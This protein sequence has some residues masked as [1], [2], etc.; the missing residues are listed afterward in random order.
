MTVN[1]R[2]RMLVPTSLFAMALSLAAGTLA[3]SQS[4]DVELPAGKGRDLVIKACSGC[5]GLKTAVEDRR[6]RTSWQDVV[7]EMKG[8]DAPV[9]DEEADALVDYLWQYFGRVNVNVA[10]EQ[11]IQAVAGLSASEAAAIVAYRTRHGDFHAL[12]ELKK[13]PRLDF[14]RI[15]A[16]RDRI[17]FTGR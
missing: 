6:T 2:R 10:S 17:A 4:N 16:R 13:V 3:L 5:H 12:E 11:E 15:E 7:D 8:L 14:R 9:V 1:M